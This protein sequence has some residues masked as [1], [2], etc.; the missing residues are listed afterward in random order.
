YIVFEKEQDKVV[1]AFYT[2]YSEFACFAGEHTGN[3]L[4]VAA[5]SPQEPQGFEATAKLDELH[6]IDAYSANDQR[7][8]SIC[9]QDMSDSNS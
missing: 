1:G 6:S 2:P 4:E 7:I 5:I 8:L 3:Q 9:K